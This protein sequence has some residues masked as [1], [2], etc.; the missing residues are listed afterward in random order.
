[1][2][3][4]Q[5]NDRTTIDFTQSEQPGGLSSE[6]PGQET[7]ETDDN[8]CR[9]H[10]HR[11]NPSQLT[12]ARDTDGAPPT[13]PS[14]LRTKSSPHAPVAI[15]ARMA[16]AVRCAQSRPM[17]AARRPCASALVAGKPPGGDASPP[18]P[19]RRALASVG[20]SAMAAAAAAMA[21]AEARVRKAECLPAQA[22][23]L[24]GA[25]DT[26]STSP[27]RV[28]ST[29][30]VQRPSP[31]AST[32]HGKPFR[33]ARYQRPAMRYRPP[34]RGGA[35]AAVVWLRA[36]GVRRRR[37]EGGARPVRRRRWRGV[38]RRPGGGSGR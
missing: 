18:P 32:S 24:A 25:S 8:P 4:R 23:R 26:T 14:P 15:C 11:Q 10:K 33:S 19:R 2:H 16:A 1:M 21:A 34:A 29:A 13:T 12:T 22:H 9:T 30:A 28:M 17:S 6:Q 31:H 20:G 36:A 3:A 5:E 37:H 7:V 35:S 38:G 27:R